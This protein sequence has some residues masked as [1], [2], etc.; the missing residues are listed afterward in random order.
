MGS[1]VGLDLDGTVGLVQSS[2]RMGTRVP[3]VDVGRVGLQ[4]G[5]WFAAGGWLGCAFGS[6]SFLS[7]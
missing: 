6:V 3:E 5:H 1:K 2:E 7:F 4:G